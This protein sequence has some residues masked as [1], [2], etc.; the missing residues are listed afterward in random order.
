MYA[1]RYGTPTRHYY[2]ALTCRWRWQEGIV[3]DR[4]FY[5]LRGRTF[6]S[7]AVHLKI[8]VICASVNFFLF[9]LLLLYKFRIIQASDATKIPEN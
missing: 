4:I 3:S 6:K 5:H 9:Y 7:T 8:R 2:N 1:M